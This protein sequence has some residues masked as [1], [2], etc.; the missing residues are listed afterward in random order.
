MVTPN[1]NIEIRTADG[2]R[3]VAVSGEHDLATPPTLAGELSQAC[4]LAT[5]IDLAGVTFL[6]ARG[7]RVLI[8]AYQWGNRSGGHRLRLVRPSRAVRRLF[9]LTG[10]LSLLAPDGEAGGGEI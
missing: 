4:S 7:L 3:H 10:T 5:V 6:D 8:S 1:F 2:V 9:E